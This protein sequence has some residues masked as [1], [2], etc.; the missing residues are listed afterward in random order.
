[1]G[2]KR[3]FKKVATVKMI[4]KKSKKKVFK[5]NFRAP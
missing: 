2:K 3:M 1:M 4:L 5:T